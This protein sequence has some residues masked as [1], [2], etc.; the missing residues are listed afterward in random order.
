[1]NSSCF[2]VIDQRAERVP[3]SFDIREQDR[4]AM[5]AKLNPGDLL[6]HFFKG[7]NSTRQRDKCVGHFKH[8]AFTLVHVARNDQVV[9]ATQS[10]FAGD[11]KLGDDACHGTTAVEHGFGDRAHNP[12]RASAEDQ[13]NAAIGESSAEGASGFHEG[14][15]GARPGSAINADCPDFAGFFVSVH[16]QA[17]ASHLRHRQGTVEKP[18]AAMGGG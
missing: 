13:V 8:F 5:T 17:C 10:V 14:R 6:N 12:D 11:Q 7:S 15:V 18:E 1:M 2:H 3:E 9:G 16:A 4:L